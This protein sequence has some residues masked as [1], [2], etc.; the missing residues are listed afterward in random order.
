MLSLYDKN[1]V[2]TED[3]K[4]VFD[5]KD[6]LKH[7]LPFNY[8]KRLIYISSCAVAVLFLLF[9][10]KP[11]KNDISNNC[12]YKKT[13]AKQNKAE[14]KQYSEITKKE[15]K[16]TRSTHYSAKQKTTTPTKNNQNIISETTEQADNISAQETEISD[17]I[18]TENTDLLADNSTNVNKDTIYIIYAGSRKENALQKVSDYVERRT[19]WNMMQTVSDVKEFVNEVKEKYFNF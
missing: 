1:F 11:I 17:N 12:D 7:K 15:S 13:V 14:I 10:L 8:R 5:N 9:L 4:I 6:S 3:K 16:Q 18:K 19:N 2:L